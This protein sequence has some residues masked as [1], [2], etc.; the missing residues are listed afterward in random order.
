MAT[1]S[2]TIEHHFQGRTASVVGTYAAILKAAR[3]LGAVKEEPKMT[4]IHLVRDSAFAGVATQKAALVLTLKSDRDVASKRVRKREQTSANRW[5]LEIRLEKPGDVDRE[6][7]G[8]IEHAYSLAGP[9]GA[10]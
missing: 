5:H 2:P 9:K 7:Q 8:W 1:V 4:S 3:A 10:R 6:I